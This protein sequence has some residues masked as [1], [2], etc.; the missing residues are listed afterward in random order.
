MLEMVEPYFSVS[1]ASRRDCTRQ[2]SSQLTSTARSRRWGRTFPDL[3]EVVG[4]HALTR[5][6]IDSRLATDDLGAERLWEAADRLTEIT[7]E[8]VDDRVGEVELVRLVDDVLAGELV[9]DEELGEVT[10]ETGSQ[11]RPGARMPEPAAYPTTLDD[12]VTLTMSPH[13]N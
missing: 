3:G 1:S 10:R 4:L 5:S 12:G 13:W 7:L 2:P 11:R 6:A 9:R 8:E